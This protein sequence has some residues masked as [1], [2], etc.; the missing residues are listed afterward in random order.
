MNYLRLCV[1]IC[2]TFLGVNLLPSASNTGVKK[3]LVEVLLK[4]AGISHKIAKLD[5]DKVFG[6]FFTQEKT[7]WEDE[8]KHEADEV[9]RG[10]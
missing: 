8:G 9:S 5:S 6:E 3:D 10:I 7:D 1:L 4:V 2:L